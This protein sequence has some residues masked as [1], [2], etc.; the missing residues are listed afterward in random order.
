MQKNKLNRAVWAEKNKVFLIDQT[1]LPFKEDVFISDSYRATCVAIVKMITRGAGSIGATA[2][3]AMMQAAYEAP[4]ENFNEFLLKAKKEIEETRPTAQDLFAAVNRVYNKALIS[5]EEAENEAHLIADETSEA[6]YLIGINGN[7]LISDGSRILTH[8]NAGPLALVEYGSALAPI[9]FAHKSGKKVFVYVDETR[10]RNQGA[11]LTA[12]ELQKAG[13]PHVIIADNAAAM[14]M[15][16]GKIDIVITGADRIAKNGDTAN[17][18]GTLEKAILAK[19]FNIPFYIAAP[20]STF[21]KEILTGNEIP[22]EERDED[23]LLYISG[24]DEN[25]KIHTVRIASPNSKAYN[26]A[27]DV[28]PVKYITAFITSGGIK[29]NRLK[30]D[31]SK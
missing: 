20:N 28:T 1:K 7:E 27:F 13:V 29:Y 5:T 26:P 25:G 14:L 10:P 3:F 31:D 11:K 19:E 8:C 9:I 21:D 6:G 4:K 12:W 16:K 30:K 15:Q 2:G 17:K 24:E 22:I 18:I 23:E